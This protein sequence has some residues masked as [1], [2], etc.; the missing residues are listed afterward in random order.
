MEELKI[1]Q[2]IY[3]MILYAEQSC[4]NQFPKVQKFVMA[5]SIRAQMHSLL[6]LC[7]TANK[8]YFKK[9]TMQD[10]DVALDILRHYIRLA[11]DL[12]YL[13]FKKYENWSKLLDEIGRMLGGWMKSLNG[14]KS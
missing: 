9:T 4:L 11:K 7:I 10:M 6:E 12:G 2:K 3:D 14:S 1:L 8:K 13:P 5:A